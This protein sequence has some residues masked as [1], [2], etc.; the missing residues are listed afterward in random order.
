MELENIPHDELQKVLN[1]LDQAIYNHQQWHN[2]LVRTLVCRLDGDE[3]DITS[4]AHKRCRFGQWYYNHAPNELLNY[5]GFT[6]IG[7]AHQNMHD[8]AAVLLNRLNLAESISTHDYDNFANALE[9]LR[10][11][12]FTLKNELESLLYEHDVLTMAITRTNM[13]TILREQQALVIRQ[14]QPCCVAMLDIDLF[15]Q[16]ND[17][18]GHLI[19]DKVLTALAQHIR[20]HL[21]PY[22]KLFRYGGE[23]FLLCIPQTDLKEGYEMMERIRLE[24][25][26]MN[27]DFG[28]EKPLNITISAGLTLLG[29]TFPVE[30]TIEH[31]DEA[32]YAAKSAGRNC[33]KIW[34]V[35]AS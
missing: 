20:K 12:I 16:I 29:T 25:A 2:S 3:N 11:E 7:I 26:A 18:H 14:N 19:G 35:D 23:E 13:L 5:P 17:H 9:K 22:D 24:V 28:L 34:N 4:E 6:A 30:Q 31:A 8:S 27:L 21:R 32:M 33:T 1:N 15:K 10:L